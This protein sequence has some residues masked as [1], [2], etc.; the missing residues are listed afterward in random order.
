MDAARAGCALLGAGSAGIDTLRFRSCSHIVWSG[1]GI[2]SIPGFGHRSGI[3]L[4]DYRWISSPGSPA[5]GNSE[6]KDGERRHRGSKDLR[7]NERW[8]TTVTEAAGCPQM[9][10]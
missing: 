8:G 7:A 6:C 9:P 4:N 5:D 10:F 3:A 1:V 2:G